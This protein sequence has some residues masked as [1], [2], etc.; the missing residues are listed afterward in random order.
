MRRKA[1]KCVASLY[2][3]EERQIDFSLVRNLSKYDESGEIRNT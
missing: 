3:L 1:E 2:I